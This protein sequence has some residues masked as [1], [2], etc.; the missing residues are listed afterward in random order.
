MNTQSY[1]VGVKTQ[2]DKDW[3]SNGLRFKTEED[4]KAYGQDLFCRWTAV[5]EWKVLESEEEPNR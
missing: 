5:N 4:A 2:G 1:K 3:V